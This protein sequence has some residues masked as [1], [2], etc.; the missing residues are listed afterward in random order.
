MDHTSVGT[1]AESMG[2]AVVVLKGANAVPLIVYQACF[3]GYFRVSARSANTG[4][5]P[6]Q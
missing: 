4:A 2:G 6:R 5:R 3:A 1:R